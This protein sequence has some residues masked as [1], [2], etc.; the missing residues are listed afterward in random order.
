M[1]KEAV[2]EAKPDIE[3]K[4][5]EML[6]ALQNG[7]VTIGE[8]VVKYSPDVA[9]AALWVVRIDGVQS[10]LNAVIFCVAGIVMYKLAKRNWKWAHQKVTKEDEED[11]LYIPSVLLF[12]LSAFPLFG[13]I[14]R[15]LSVWT[16]IAIFQ[17]KLYL[18]KQI[19]DAAV[20]K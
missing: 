12:V 8:Q 16:Y 9:D 11:I 15:L 3:T 13:G 14:A 1:S 2:A 5:V 10:L 19:I 20:G 7:A 6:D 17:P 18:A 4:V